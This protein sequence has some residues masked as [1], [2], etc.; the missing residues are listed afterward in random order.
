[1]VAWLQEQ[2]MNVSMTVPNKIRIK[3]VVC[4]Y[5]PSDDVYTLRYDGD[6]HRIDM[7]TDEAIQYQK[8]LK[9]H[10]EKRGESEHG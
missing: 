8:W 6:I 1:M 5:W 4:E 3:D 7:T 2:W 9:A 10:L